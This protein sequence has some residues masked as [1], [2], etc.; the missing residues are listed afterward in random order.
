[1]LLHNRLLRTSVS[2]LA[3][4]GVIGALP[5]FAHAAAPAPAATEGSAQLEEIVVT[6]QKREE[7]L[8][9]V[10]ITVSSFSAERM[11]SAALRNTTDL[12]T[13]VPGLVFNTSFNAG[14]PSLRGINHNTAAVSDESPV[15]TFVDGVY[16]PNNIASLFTLSNVER[17]EVLKG[18]QGTLFGR[19]ATAGVLNVTTR[20]PQH[21][22]SMDVSVGYAN[23]NTLEGSFYGTTGITETLAA[24]LA[25]H[26]RS[27]RDGWGRNVYLNEPV[28]RSSDVTM[29]GKLLF[30]PNDATRM[31]LIG[32]NEGDTGSV[33]FGVAPGATS[34]DRIT[35]YIS[36]YDVA[37]AV[38]PNSNNANHG[39]S[40]EIDHD[41]GWARLVNI[42]AYQH[43]RGAFT[44][45]QSAG[46]GSTL[47]GC[48][49]PN[50]RNLCDSINVKSYTPTR[51][52]TEEFRL[53]SPKESSFS[54]VGGLYFLDDHSRAEF[55]LWGLATPQRQ[56]STVDTTSLAAFGQVT[57]KFRED[58]RLTVGAR[59]T[60]DKRSFSGLAT[61][62]PGFPNSVPALTPAT[63]VAFTSV[64]P[65]LPDSK[66]WSKPTFRVS[67]DHNF[68]NTV[69]G[70]VSWNR[71]FK[72]GAYNISSFGNP[73]V[74]PE[75]LDAYEAGFKSEFF[76]RRIRLNGSGFYYDYSNIQLRSVNVAQPGLI[77]L[78]NA[79][80]GQLYG[81]DGDFEA[82]VTHNL[83]LS[84][85]FEYLHARY[86][87]FPHGPI[88]TR[89]PSGQ[90][91]VNPDGNLSGNIMT[92]APEYTASVQAEYRVPTASGE[93]AANIA[94]N[95]NSG[96][97][98]DPDN[99]FRQNAYSLLNASLKW[100]APSDKWDVR[101]WAENL[102][103]THRYAAYNELAVDIYQPAPPR[104][105]GITFTAHFR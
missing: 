6:A 104:T 90:N 48:V 91:F 85:G 96:F 74:A 35:R 71:G 26:A 39:V 59:Y 79:A 9:S 24:D 58:T 84:G 5:T 41:M 33:A 30:T 94:Y 101:L 38:R 67:L 8:Q 76:D 57:W 92:R 47:P 83:T 97:Y 103:D 1:M 52:W 86:T 15:A 98:F 3:L 100:T 102:T 60:S 28:W 64:P 65:N 72:S 34:N 29:R 56:V 21:T 2:R 81:V 66:S 44:Y 70:Y 40:L 46:V 27:Q 93:Y 62:L 10:P 82:A 42:A 73:P 43:T 89:L 78:L 53:E 77:L 63:G 69:M 14:I 36:F 99:R 54:W 17:V 11:T 61:P 4:V 49:L 7:N 95:Y 20:T 23:Y 87:S 75:V 18:P 12:A 22:P 80:K 55:E 16:V 25:V 51:T 45:T 31:V 88:T 13:L 37:N 68:S 50:G 19:N 32:S 105:Y